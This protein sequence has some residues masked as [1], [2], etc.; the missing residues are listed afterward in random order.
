MPIQ[1][2]Y[3]FQIVQDEDGNFVR[4]TVDKVFTDHKDIYSEE[5]KI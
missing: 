1:D 5:C 2:F 3:L 4:K